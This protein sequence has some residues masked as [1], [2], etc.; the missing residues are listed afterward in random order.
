MAKVDPIYCKHMVKVKHM[1]H[2][3]HYKREQAEKKCKTLTKQFPTEL[4]KSY[5]DL[6]GYS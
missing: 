2:W 5:C 6:H 3:H 4:S 1:E